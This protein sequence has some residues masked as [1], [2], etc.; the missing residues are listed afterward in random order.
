MNHMT[1]NEGN[2]YIEGYKDHGTRKIKVQIEVKLVKEVEIEVDD[3]DVLDDGIDEDGNYWSEDDFSNCDLK[4]AAFEELH[5]LEDICSKE[6]WEL[7]DYDV[8]KI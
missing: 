8:E 6:D 7:W 3:F 5:R 2:P 1:H 4:E